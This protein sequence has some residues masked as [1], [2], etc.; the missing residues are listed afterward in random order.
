MGAKEEEECGGE[1]RVE[2]EDGG[3]AVSEEADGE[4][5]GR[6]LGSWSLHEGD[7]KREAW[8]YCG[9]L[10]RHWLSCVLRWRP[11]TAALTSAERLRVALCCVSTAA[12]GLSDQIPPDTMAA[13]RFLVAANWK[14][15]PATKVG[16][17]G[18]KCMSEATHLPTFP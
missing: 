18:V 16:G 2:N 12:C 9:Q 10:T 8:S 1:E 6:C 4:R 17:N 5:I 15:N 11:P 13:R 3:Y 7:P 14:L